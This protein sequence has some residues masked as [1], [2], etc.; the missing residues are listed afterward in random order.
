MQPQEMKQV[1]DQYVQAY[2]TFDID[3]MLSLMHEDIIFK[4]ISGIRTNLSTKGK[5]EFV[6]IAE[7]AKEIFSSR[8]QKI[9]NYFFDSNKAV[10]E[11]DF[12]GILKLDLDDS[13]TS[14]ERLIFRDKFVFKFK[15]GLIVSLVDCN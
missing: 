7:Q 4:I 12:E 3:G 15:D 8:C 11:M 10:V 13:I 14:G 5:S 2:N 9:R 6:E 1:V